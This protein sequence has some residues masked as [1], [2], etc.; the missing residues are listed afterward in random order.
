MIKAP[1]NFVPVND[2]VYYP[3]WAEQVSHDVPF[4]DGESGTVS[5]SMTAISPIFVRNGS[6][7]ENETAF[8]NI[9]NR[10]FIPATSIKGM[11]RNVM[12]IMCLGKMQFV[13]DRRF[14]WRDLSTTNYTENFTE[15]IK[16]KP[17]VRAGYIE[18]INGDWKLKPCDYARIEQRELDPSIGTNKLSAIDKYNFW[19]KTPGRT[20]INNF[21]ISEEYSNDA[22]VKQCGRYKRAILDKDNVEVRYKKDKVGNGDIKLHYE[23]NVKGELVFTG[24][25]GPRKDA[26]EGEHGKGK[27]HL[28]FV[29]FNEDDNYLDI[30]DSMRKDFELNHSDERNK[31]NHVNALSPNEEWGYWKPGLQRGERM[32]VFWLEN[33]HTSKVDSFGLAMLYRLPLIQTV[34]DQLKATSSKHVEHIDDGKFVENKF[35]PDLIDSVFGYT[36][37]KKSLKGRI[38]FSHA[39]TINPNPGILAM[40]SEV[41][42]SPK[43]TYYPTYLKEGDYSSKNKISGWKR[44]PVH[45]G[46]STSHSRNEAEN[47]N[48]ETQFVPLAA[49]TEFEFK[50]KFHNLKK[51][52]IGALLSALTFHYTSG[53]FHS[54]GMAK[55][56]GYGKVSLKI[57]TSTLQLDLNEYLKELEKELNI[58][59]Y[60]NSFKKDNKN[61]WAE[62]LT[63]LVTMA[64]EQNNRGNSVLEYMQLAEFVEA[65]NNNER[66]Q[67]YSKLHN[68]QPK[69]INALLSEKDLEETFSVFEE[70]KKKEKRDKEEAEKAAEI[71]RNE[72]I[73][74]DKAAAEAAT[75]AAAE[76]AA[77]AKNELILAAGISKALE[78]KDVGGVVADTLKYK[79]AKGKALSAEEK[80]QVIAKILSFN[81]KKIKDTKK[82]DTVWKKIREIGEDVATDLKKALG[83]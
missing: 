36:V 27:K 42:G 58:Y 61:N 23:D 2:K 21:S 83:I 29:F 4:S 59:Y 81:D 43:A 31:D 51:C 20:L 68:I 47:E 72:E 11:V 73:S 55:S 80:D 41:L 75:K 53:C 50:I 54:L 49:G 77:K 9:N 62:S 13:D 57:A 25:I 18:Q 65:K 46:A 60:N 82:S 32:P 8:S 69:T 19:L 39:F 6:N 45:Q 10:F 74:K 24:Q 16:A 37:G 3:E 56:L 33:I 64:S 76:A 44:Y 35:T 71:A 26:I 5:V 79:D 7:L 70:K 40:Q 22:F 30:P 48:I 78:K 67:R 66:L 1:Y 17:K 34:H 28:E 63:E 14:S 38:Q 15:S 12:E 52:E